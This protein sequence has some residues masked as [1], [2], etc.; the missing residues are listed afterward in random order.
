MKHVLILGGSS[1]IG[2]KVISIFLKM[3]WSVT[4]HYFKN[5][6]RLVFLQKKNKN[7]NLKF[8]FN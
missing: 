3:N 4:A 1:D 7:L 8:K 5:K 6:N 2:F